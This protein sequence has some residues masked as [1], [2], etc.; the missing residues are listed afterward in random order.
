M[1]GH[2]AV[3][4]PDK[5]GWEVVDRSDTGPGYPDGRL[6]ATCARQDDA[7]AVAAALNGHPSLGPEPAALSAVDEQTALGWLD[8]AGPERVIAESLA[9]DLE[10]EGKRV[11][12]DDWREGPHGDALRRRHE[13]DARLAAAALREAAR[14]AVSRAAA[15]RTALQDA[16]L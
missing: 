15:V 1:P 3:R 7:T 14:V 4:S 8:G 9:F 12:R 6:V 2:T 16:V 13:R 11:V 10:L 5:R